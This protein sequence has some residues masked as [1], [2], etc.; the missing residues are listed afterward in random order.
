M[1]FKIEFEIDIHPSEIID[2]DNEALNEFIKC[3]CGALSQKSN[4]S[5]FLWYE[6][7]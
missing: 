6:I 3:E 1:K 7:S 4:K 2:L 5:Q